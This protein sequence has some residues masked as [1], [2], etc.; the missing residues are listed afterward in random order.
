MENNIQYLIYIP[1]SGVTKSKTIDHRDQQT[2][3]KLIEKYIQ[4][5]QSQKQVT[6]ET[7]RQPVCI[8]LLISVLSVGLYGQLFLTL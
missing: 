6:I 5:L 8:S 1:K 7:N 2:A 4:E 3:L